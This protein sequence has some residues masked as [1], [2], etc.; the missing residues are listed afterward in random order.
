MDGIFPHHCL[1]DGVARSCAANQK[2]DARDDRE[3]YV[4]DKVAADLAI[5]TGAQASI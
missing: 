5:S 4:E 2:R 1:R 3:G